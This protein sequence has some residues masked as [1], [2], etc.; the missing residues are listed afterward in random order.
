MK[1]K[2]IVF[3]SLATAVTAVSLNSLAKNSLDSDS[4]IDANLKANIENEN[5]APLPKPGSLAETSEAA[6][7]PVEMPSVSKGAVDTF[8]SYAK[9]GVDATYHFFKTGVENFWDFC[10]R[11]G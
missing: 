4:V 9:S 6:K 1:L 2:L 7:R 3:V 10:K 11:T 8:W 5:E